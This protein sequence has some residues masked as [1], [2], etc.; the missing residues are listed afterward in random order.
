MTA[1]TARC[2][3]CGTDHEIRSVEVKAVGAAGERLKTVQPSPGDVAVCAE[4][5]AF[6]E[7]VDVDGELQLRSPAR[8]RMAALNADPALQRTR[9]AAAMFRMI[10]G[11]GG[12]PAMPVV[13]DVYR[14][15]RAPLRAAG[16]EPFGPRRGKRGQA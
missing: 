12:G 7:I 6:V 5:L 9:L 8:D 15:A 16:L 2:P 10:H 4:C 14:D 1:L 13:V 3:S 11:R